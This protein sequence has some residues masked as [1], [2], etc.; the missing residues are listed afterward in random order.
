MIDPYGPPPGHKWD[1]PC[2]E[3]QDAR[4]RWAAAQPPMIEDL[5]ADD[6]EDSDEDVAE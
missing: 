4:E 1:C 5:P 2:D 6:A 3:C